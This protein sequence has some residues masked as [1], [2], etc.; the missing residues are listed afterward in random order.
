ML[1]ERYLTMFKTAQN[2]AIT[3]IPGTPYIALSN[4]QNLTPQAIAARDIRLEK[5]IANLPILQRDYGTIV[6]VGAFIG[7]TALIFAERASQVFA[8]EAQEDAY[9][10]AK[11]NANAFNANMGENRII[12]VHSP[13]GNGSRVQLNQDEIGGNLGTRTV[14]HG[15]GE[16][17]MRLDAYF[18]P[19]KHVDIIKIDVEGHEPQVLEG[20]KELIKRCKPYL[21][22][23]IYHEML[24]RNGKRDQDVYNILQEL[25]Y[26]WEVCV[27]QI[28][29]PRF[30]ILCK[31]L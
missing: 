3:T 11:W 22:I 12:V 30:D 25:G 4:D 23:E 2:I 19:K 28:H 17:A 24:E 16:A 13:V 15:E 9:L 20:A 5:S 14:K 8:F 21:I 29:E 31:P 27:G 1:E 18:G 7:D 10:C 26:G 6:D